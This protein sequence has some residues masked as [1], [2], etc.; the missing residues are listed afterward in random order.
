MFST[1]IDVTNGGCLSLYCTTPLFCPW[2]CMARKSHGKGTK[3][4]EF[5]KPNESRG[6]LVM[7]NK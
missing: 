3:T 1:I 5:S 6:K 2:L 4:K 7:H